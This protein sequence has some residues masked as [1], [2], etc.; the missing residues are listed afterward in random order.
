M[1]TQHRGGAGVVGLGVGATHARAFAADP[2]CALRWL[3]DPDRTRATGVALDVGEGRV[4]DSLEQILDD[5]DVAVMAIASPDDAHHQQVV[6]SLE[7][8]K[9]VFVE[10]PI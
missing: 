4:A 1:T 2:R 9:H 8:D 5:A 3:Y 7:H 6:A 10:K